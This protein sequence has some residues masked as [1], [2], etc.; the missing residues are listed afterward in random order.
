MRVGG[1]DSGVGSPAGTTENGEAMTTAVRTAGLTDTADSWIGY[2]ERAIQVTTILMAVVAVRLHEMIP[3]SSMLQPMITITI[4]A[5]ALLLTQTSPAARQAAL[6]HP[7]TRWVLAYLIF[8]AVTIPFA[9]WQ[10]MAFNTVKA[11]FPA[12]LMFLAIMLCPPR[13]AVL[14]RLQLIFITLVLAYAGYTQLVGNS[15]RGRLYT[16]GGYYDTNDMAAMLAI[17]FPLAA[18]L[19]VRASPGRQRII[20]IVAVVILVLGVIASGSRGGT[21]A[22]LAGA[23]VFALGLRGTRGVIAI[24]AMVIGGAVAWNTASP[25]FRARMLTLTNL[26]G[27]YNMTSDVGRKAV[28]ERG[29]Q[30][31]RENFLIGVGA[32]NFPIAEGGFNADVGQAGWK[33]SAAHN[34]YIQAFAELGTIGGGI[35]VAILLGAARR[36]IP[37]WKGRRGRA[38]PF[39]RPELLAGLAAFAS[40]AYFLS[41]AYF[42]PLFALVGLMALAHRVA[43]WEATAV[44]VRPLADDRPIRV[45][46]PGERGG[47]SLAWWTPAS[48]AEPGPST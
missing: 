3:G 43:A 38:P 4:P 11:T 14:D 25:D 35:F 16:V 39:E 37:L 45:R 17:A 12:V 20:G 42:Q 18:G 44:T 22:L 7:Q 32:G 48:R 26:E 10:A 46:R 5:F 29:R 24:V 28:W 30:Y 9:L 23:V 40:A 19:V 1:L 33:W 21:L 15:W 31:W 27:D 8:M 6:A 2:S 41:H 34:A 47:G 13:R 36:A